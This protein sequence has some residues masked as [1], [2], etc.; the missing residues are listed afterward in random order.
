MRKLVDQW[1][2]NGAGSLKSQAAT[3]RGGARV[4]DYDAT[5]SD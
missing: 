5:E 4:I 3:T 1:Q 2:T